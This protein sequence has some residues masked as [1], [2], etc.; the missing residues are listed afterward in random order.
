[1]DAG[2]AHSTLSAMAERPGG[3]TA[4]RI[5]SYVSRKVV[6]FSIRGVFH[7]RYLPLNVVALQDILFIAIA[8]WVGL[9]LLI[10]LL[11]GHVLRIVGSAQPEH[12]LSHHR[13]LPRSLL[14]RD[15]EQATAEPLSELAR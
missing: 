11:V 14:A 13:R 3:Q 15:R 1:V 6:S 8:S 7:P 2:D 10:G 12:T 4:P 9:S 5:H